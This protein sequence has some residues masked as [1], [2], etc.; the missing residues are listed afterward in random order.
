M[1]LLI[2]LFIGFS[3]QAAK[4][5]ITYFSCTVKEIVKSKKVDVEVK[6]AI[7]DFKPYEGSGELIQYPGSN[8]EY[9][10][11][12]VTPMEV[13]GYYTKMSNLNGQGGDLSVTSGGDIHLF[14]DGDGYQYTDLV[15]WDDGDEDLAHTEGY[16]RDYGSA[17]A[18]G[19]ETFKQFIQCKRSTNVL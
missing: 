8:E 14:G 9:G 15:L 7:K 16:T 6:F 2:A 1:S 12:S 18:D 10:A 4:Q 5:E 11:I 13:N 17:Y 19:E 3:A